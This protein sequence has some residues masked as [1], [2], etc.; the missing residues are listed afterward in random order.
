MKAENTTTGHNRT[1][2]LT[3]IPD[4]G[5]GSLRELVI[6]INYKLFGDNDPYTVDKAVTLDGVV[7][8]TI[9]EAINK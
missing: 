1:I 9:I 7:I 3:E 2:R 4:N 8:P 5:K 6:T